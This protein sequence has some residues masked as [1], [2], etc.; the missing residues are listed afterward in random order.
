MSLFPDNL[1]AAAANVM[2]SA[3]K[4]KLR[5]VTAES[6]TGGLLS[7]CLTELPGAS[8]VF[9]RGFVTYADDAKMAQLDVDRKTL[10][11]FGAVSAETAV[12][13]AEGALSASHADIAV[14]ITG[15][16]GPG[17]GSAD[18][19]VGTVFIALAGTRLKNHSRQV[20]SNFAGDRGAV[21]LASVAAALEALKG[22][23][24]EL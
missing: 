12:E 13:M 15:V 6:C 20:R 17:G 11:D 23:I 18:K 19:P 9:D 5:I 14:S 22:A 16:S 24:E 21:R 7:A 8:D 10:G 3:R 4:K 2:D 1:R